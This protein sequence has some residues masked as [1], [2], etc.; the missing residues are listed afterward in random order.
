MELNDLDRRLIAAI[1]D[2]MPLV[3]RPY[4]AIGDALGMGEAEVIAGLRRLIEGG[5]IRRF[6]VIVRHHELGYRANAMVVWDVPDAR[7]GDAGRTLA[8]LPFV[9]LCY[10]RPRRLPLWPYNM[11]CM[12]HGRD[13]STVETLVEQTT[14]TAGLE[15]LPRAV[16]FSRRRFKQRGA[17]YAAPKEA[18]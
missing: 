8:G 11:F 15:G 10:R 17:R 6:G 13:R 7:V 9:T 1:Q 12:I 16:L 14:A 3:P 4:A 5:V 18:A 2:G